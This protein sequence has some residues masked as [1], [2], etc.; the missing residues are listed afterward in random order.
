MVKK[1]RSAPSKTSI[2][3]NG[4]FVGYHPDGKSLANRLRERRR[5]NELNSQVNIYYAQRLNELHILTDKG[6]VRRPY[7]VV[8]N[9]KSRLAPE[10]MARIKNNELSWGHL[11]KMGI[12]E[13]LD[14]Q[15]EENTFVAINEKDLTPEHTHLE[16]DP[17]NL[18]GVVAGVLPYP[19]HN[20]SPRITMGCAMAKQSLGIYTT[21][22]RQRYDTRGYVM[23]YPQQPLVQTSLY[24]ALNLKQK[25]AGQNCVVAL[26][27][28]HGYNMADA[29]VVNKSSIDRGLHRITMF[30][31]YETEERMYPGGQ[32]DKIELPTPDVV[33]Y[34]GEI[35][36]R[37]LGEDGIIIPESEIKSKDV[38]VG[39]TSP[40]RFLE[41]ISVFGTVEEK[42]RE[43]SLS[44]K[45]GESGR[46]D[47]IVV[48]EGPSGNRLVK[49]RVRSIKIPEIGD[50]LA[51]RHG[52]KGV[53]GL[54][55][56][57]EDMPFTKSGIVP[58][59]IVNPHAIPSRMT[60]GHLLETLGGKAACMGGIIANGTAFSGNTEDEYKEILKKAG[61]QEYGEEV[62]YDGTT[63]KKIISK[64]FI[65]TIYYQRLHHLVSNKMHVRSRGPVQLLT[66][67]PTEGRAREGGLRFGE[68][69][70]DCLIGYGAS[71]LIKERLLE[72]SDKT[73][74]LICTECGSIATHD[75]ARNRDIC[76]ICQ[77]ESVEPVEMS[78]AFKLLLDEI[79]SL[80]I[81][82][83]IKL[84]DKG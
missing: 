34:R 78:Y 16:V 1:K 25:A 33:G 7:I 67:Q 18:F 23:Y 43:S 30:K 80:Y 63:G 15:E 56:P 62:L 65:G 46:V 32:K 54:L 82:P 51:S 24:K 83:R 55:V 22:F 10:V 40:P 20:S 8:E 72:E 52:Q 64:I 36:Y 61:F 71:M 53:I 19:E 58:D 77:C 28:Y 84:R 9:G 49:V 37:H 2:F 12:I 44:L 21:N 73:I 47:S 76:P 81:F 68:M 29:I 17:A 75:Y 27:S 13:Y 3:L 4:K 26:T 57:Q 60:A 45:A 6:R 39:K 31:T 59:L 41:E 70:R 79:K 11:I 50:K 14:A 66:H 35:V 48:T 38:L 42:K 74:Q 69:E 5:M